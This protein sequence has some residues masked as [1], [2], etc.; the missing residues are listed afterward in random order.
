MTFIQLLILVSINA[1]LEYFLIK[2]EIKSNID[3]FYALNHRQVDKEL[4]KY[5]NIF[6]EHRF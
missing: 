1:I 5:E 2:W 3:L 6:N 4:K